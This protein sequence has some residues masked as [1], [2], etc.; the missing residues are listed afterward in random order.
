MKAVRH[1]LRQADAGD[2]ALCN[3]VGIEDSHKRRLP[4]ASH[5]KP[6]K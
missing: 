6:T 3:V 1:P 5:I 4:L 2:R